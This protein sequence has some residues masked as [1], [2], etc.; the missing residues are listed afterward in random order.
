MAPRRHH[1]SAAPSE[2]SLVSASGLPPWP[3]L[4]PS[5]GLG[6]VAAA[7][8]A[9]LVKNSYADPLPVPGGSASSG[10]QEGWNADDSVLGRLGLSHVLVL[11][12]KRKPSRAAK[13][14]EDA[15]QLGVPL[16]MHDAT[17]GLWNTS[18]RSQV[19]PLQHPEGTC[20]DL[21][22]A[23]F[24]TH[25]RA[26]HVA[27][28]AALPTLLLED[29]VRLPA[30]FI[31]FFS[32]RMQALPQDF[33]VALAGSSVTSAA[34]PV[35][36]LLSRPDAEDPNGQAFLGLWGYVVSPDGARLLL[37]MADE[38]R[39]GRRRFFQPVDLF[40]AHRLRQIRTYAMEPPAVLAEEF[41]QMKDTPILSTMR[42]VGVI[43]LTAEPST[44]RPNQDEETAEME[45]LSSKVVELGEKGL[46][47]KS[48]KVAR[49]A[50]RNMRRYSCWH[51]AQLLQNAGVSLLRLL[52]EGNHAFGFAGF[53][54]ANDTLLGSLEAL[55]SS[56]RYTS[57]TWMERQKLADF[58][59]WVSNALH[60]MQQNGETPAAPPAGWGVR[61][62]LPG[63]GWLRASSPPEL[64]ELLP[65]DLEEGMDLSNVGRFADP[66]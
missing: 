19:L 29:D 32:Q 34:R 16:E 20:A 8:L 12:L 48:W 18:F 17:D 4:L 45:R 2:A 5:L 24:N 10:L 44:N 46:S 63:G 41:R 1:A 35:S 11:R 49:K 55:A 59:G 23:I 47:L 58:P 56:V 30:D 43:Y 42:Q 14:A 40:M 25:E 38:V 50:L 31:D 13:L 27:A 36:E 52:S 66:S 61:V 37:Q 53:S 62:P 57:G 9:G 39:L 6:A 33:H 21:V 3:W 51:A 64:V 26:W 60:H 28:D 15:E 65:L 54:N 7:A 22:G